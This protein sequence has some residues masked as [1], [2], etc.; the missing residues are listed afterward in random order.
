MIQIPLFSSFG[1]GAPTRSLGVP[2]LQKGLW[3]EARLGLKA[4]PEGQEK[5]QWHPDW[6]RR[7]LSE[8]WVPAWVS[9]GASTLSLALLLLRYSRLIGRQ[10]TRLKPKGGH[11]RLSF[12][13]AGRGNAITDEQSS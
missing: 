1:K 13:A 6:L 4:P 5:G 9:V 7:L 10:Q 8:L 2:G 3:E 12:G 11:R